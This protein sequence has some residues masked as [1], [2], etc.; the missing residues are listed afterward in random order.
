LGTSYI[1]FYRK[2]RPQQFKDLIGQ[3]AI[4]KTLSSA[5]KLNKVA[6]AYLFTGPRG[7]GKTSTARIFAKSL[8]CEKGPTLEP[9]GVC[10]S[11]VDIA[12]GSAIDVIEIDAASNRK[13]EDARNLL[14]KVQFV[15][16]A[17]KYKIYIID[18]VHMLTTE[19]F[20]TLLKTLEEPPANLVFI[21]ATTEAHK[22][23]KTIISRC[24]RFDFRRIRQ[25]LIVERLK[26]ICKLENL[27]IDDEALTLIARRS[28]GG[29]RD[30]LSLLDQVSILANIQE[31]I[32]AKDILNLLGCLQED[33]LLKLVETIADKNS[34]GLLGILNEILELGNEP[35]QI[36]RELM[37]YFRNLML[38]KTSD[39][40]EEIRP[41]I[42]VSDQ[43]YGELKKQCD[44]F[45]VAEIPQIIEKLSEHEKILKTTSKQHLWLEVALISILHRQDIKV[46]KDLEQRITKLETVLSGGNVQISA[47]KINYTAVQ[48]KPVNIQSVSKPVI[49]ETA[50]AT[51]TKELPAQEAVQE[52]QSVPVK[53]QSSIDIGDLASSWGNLLANIESIPTRTLFSEHARPVEINVD[54][55]I[56]NFAN[57][58]HLKLAQSK[59]KMGPFEKATQKVFG[60]VPNIVFRQGIAE[61]IE[62][63]K[64]APVPVTPTPAKKENFEQISQDFEEIPQ[65][66][67][68]KV[69]VSE[70]PQSPIEEDVIEEIK[71]IEKNVEQINL[72]ENA[73]MIKDLFQGK[74]IE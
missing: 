42:D 37:N 48:P 35:V 9:C 61:K 13:V 16:V 26:H 32:A 11:C 70:S 41:L 44:K 20:N 12:S 54:K 64:K 45:D 14:E 2:Y 47:P 63:P 3:E 55:I 62:L 4:S 6:H 53:S 30:A 56:L 29:M 65:K 71:E 66:P 59:S 67:P 58:M 1:P 21:L 52:N 23:L 24:Q 49:H 51:I 28:S 17:G 46:I 7:T 72:S 74:I 27:N 34:A 5:I 22:V 43:F 38:I 39:N 18:E 8:N 69:L 68:S 15:P 50:T 31:K 10:P 73:K 60:V 33:T 57:D 40:L 25:D 36:I 19:A